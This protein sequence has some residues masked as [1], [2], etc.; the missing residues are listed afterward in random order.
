MS[1]SQML[2][3]SDSILNYSERNSYVKYIVCDI[4]GYDINHRYNQIYGEFYDKCLKENIQCSPYVIEEFQISGMIE[5]LFENLNDEEKIGLAKE[6]FEKYIMGIILSFEHDDYNLA[7]LMFVRMNNY[8]RKMMD[9]IG[10]LAVDEYINFN[11]EKNNFV[12]VKKY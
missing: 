11:D 7:F 2:M 10:I 12:L 3:F 6:I 5:R 1:E 8:L 4:L 9:N